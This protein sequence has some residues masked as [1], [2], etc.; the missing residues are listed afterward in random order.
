[1]HSIKCL[2]SVTLA[3]I[4]CLGVPAHSE[5]TSK[6]IPEHT[7]IRSQPSANARVV[8]SFERGHSLLVDMV[9]TGSDAGWCLV[10]EPGR[11][12]SAG[13]VQCNHLTREA[14]PQA[15]SVVRV[16]PTQPTTTP[17]NNSRSAEPTSTAGFPA[18]GLWSAQ[19]GLTEDQR[20]A[21]AQ[22][23]E[24]YGLAACRDD[25]AQTYRRYGVTDA[26]SLLKR[27]GEMG[28]NP[29]G[30]SF[31]AAVEPKIHRGGARYKAFWQAFWNT[32]TAEQR[33][34]STNV[35]R[36]ALAYLH[37]QSDPEEAFNGYVLQHM[38]QS[39][40]RHAQREP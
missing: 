17:T 38:R 3:G 14:L 12:E 16:E 13:Y 23:F 18:L 15:P 35:P 6:V 20:N 10:R 4:L 19:L 11:K 40:G 21:V 22:S 29:F 31:A 37:S 7:A 27:M 1:M 9:I 32:L 8:G 34:K 30:D 2:S 25:L 26:Y 5:E 39:Q 28:K 24:S 36:F 33:T